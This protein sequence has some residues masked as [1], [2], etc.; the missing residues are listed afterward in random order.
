MNEGKTYL[1]L[2]DFSSKFLAL[3]T[4][5]Y[6]N[7]TITEGYLLLTHSPAEIAWLLKLGYIREESNA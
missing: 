4:C 3:V 1:V 6:E 5:Y 2:R 7:H